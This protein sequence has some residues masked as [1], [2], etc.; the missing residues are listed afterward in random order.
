MKKSILP[1]VILFSAIALSGCFGNSENAQLIDDIQ[2]VSEEI[3]ETAETSETLPV[4]DKTAEKADESYD[5]E[6]LK[7]PNDFYITVTDRNGDKKLIYYMEGNEDKTS[8]AYM[9]DYRDDPEPYFGYISFVGGNI[10]AKTDSAFFG[11]ELENFIEKAGMTRANIS[12]YYR[13]S[14]FASNTVSIYKDDENG[15]FDELSK[16][17]TE[18]DPEYV[19]ELA[20]MEESDGAS[21]SLTQDLGW[22][23][24]DPNF[25]YNSRYP[26]TSINLYP[27]EHTHS[28]PCIKLT[29]SQYNDRPVCRMGIYDTTA[30]YELLVSQEQ[31]VSPED[32]EKAYYESTYRVS[33]WFYADSGAFYDLALEYVIKSD[34]NEFDN[35]KQEHNSTVYSSKSGFSENISAYFNNYDDVPAGYKLHNFKS[36][37]FILP[38]D[39][40]P[41]T[42]N[43][44][45]L[46]SRTGDVPVTFRINVTG[47]TFGEKEEL[48]NEKGTFNNSVCTYRSAYYPEMET[49]IDTLSFQDISEQRYS[50]ELRIK[51]PERTEDHDKLVKDIFGSFSL[52]SPDELSGA[53]ED[54]TYS[55]KLS[56]EPVNDNDGSEIADSY[57]ATGNNIYRANCPGI[58]FAQFYVTDFSKNYETGFECY[59][60]KQEDDG[61]WYR[62]EPLGGDIIQA[63]N[64]AGHFYNA[65]EEGREFITLD[66]AAYPLLPQGHYRAAKPFWEEGSA[67]HEQYFVFYDF[68]MDEKANEP[69]PGTAKCGYDEYPSYLNELG[70]NEI[71]Y[72]VDI[73]GDSFIESEIVDIERLE[74]DDWV[75]VRKYPVHTNSIGGSYVMKFPDMEETVDT[76]DF[77]IS[78]PG[79]YRLRISIGK[80]GLKDLTSDVDMFVDNYDTV[81]AYFK[82][83]SD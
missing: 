22:S 81:Y 32:L 24:Y 56:P 53:A 71:A 64:G 69:V 26:L 30:M 27:T 33:D 40:E 16:A 38:D 4:S 58:I 82:I 35:V 6:S 43:N 55:L 21:S 31:P 13:D 15:W 37:Y 74:G 59:I 50:V 14:S 51:S 77:D 75:S 67:D 47:T 79:E 7:G 18:L 2:T 41:S 39:K 78:V 1:A 11:P 45:L 19:A 60:E 80:Y 34:D 8:I 65:L 28:D 49:Y 42:I 25:S 73:N 17:I 63:N 70:G 72:T 23:E 52:Y 29:F 48:V 44:S 66:L 62:V 10:P 61:N 57:S 5:D 9:E 54:T 12:Y 20:G 3:S 36:V 83:T 68:Y 46:W 76:S